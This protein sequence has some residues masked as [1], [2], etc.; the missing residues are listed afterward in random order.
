MKRTILLFSLFC[1]C[2]AYGQD[3]IVTNIGGLSEIVPDGQVGF[4]VEPDPPSISHAIEKIYENNRLQQMSEN[5]IAEKRRFSWEYFAE[6]VE[7]LFERV[8][9][10]G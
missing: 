2:I 9:N 4:V 6:Q 7:K 5:M 3:L 8:K 10:Y 1:S